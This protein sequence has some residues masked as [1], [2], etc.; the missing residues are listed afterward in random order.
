DDKA[1][2]AR[3]LVRDLFHHGQEGGVDHHHAVLGVVDDPGDLFGEKPRVHGMADRAD[4]HDAV[5]AF[6][7][8][9]GVPGDGSDAIA[10]LDAV[11]L[12]ALR[13]FQGASVNLGVI[14]AINRA[15]HAACHNLLG[16]MELGRVLDYA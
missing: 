6:E 2:H 12:Q 8:A 16:A 15:F 7:M 5:P 11:A 1:L 9:P 14:G 3:H 10:E 13:D 4:A